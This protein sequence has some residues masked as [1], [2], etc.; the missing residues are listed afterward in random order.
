MKA[1]IEVK[2]GKKRTL[3]TGICLLLTLCVLGFPAG[4]NPGDLRTS[5]EI[6]GVITAYAADYPL[7]GKLEKTGLS[8]CDALLFYNGKGQ[9]ILERRP[10]QDGL[11]GLFNYFGLSDALCHALFGESDQVGTG[12]RAA[13]GDSLLVLAKVPLYQEA[14]PD[15]TEPDEGNPQKR[16]YQSE[17]NE[18][19]LAIR[20]YLNSFNWEGESELYRAQHA[21][22]F[23]A[24]TCTYDTD[25]YTRF[26]AGEDVQGDDA[27]TAY[28]CLVNH[29]AVCEGISISYQLLTRAMGLQSFCAPDKDDKDHMF[30]FVKADGNWYKVD[31]AVIGL[32][33]QSLVNRC[34]KNT[35]NEEAVQILS[36]YE[37]YCNSRGKGPGNENSGK[38]EGETSKALPPDFSALAPGK[39]QDLIGQYDRQRIYWLKKR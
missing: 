11:Y 1:G 31:L 18:L 36:A 9:A 38:K 23:L 30:A 14:E 22:L 20:S 17:R 7:E 32:S 2:I 10:R 33:P 25:L 12:E 8:Y 37:T 19:A 4:P 5:E 27:F 6:S 15:L 26:S 28:G 39:V 35:V 16:S 24:S 29:K 3:K 13:D 21:A 34:F